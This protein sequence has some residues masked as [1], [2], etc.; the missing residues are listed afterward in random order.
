MSDVRAADLPDDSVVAVRDR[1]WIKIARSYWRCTDGSGGN[2]GHID[3]LLANGAQV[4]RV[5]TGGE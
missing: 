3:G 5:G 2:D 1:A 4:L